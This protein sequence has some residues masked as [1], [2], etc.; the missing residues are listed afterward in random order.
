M[1]TRRSG[2]V[3]PIRRMARRTDIVPARSSS[4]ATAAHRRRIRRLT[5]PN[6]TR[7]RVRIPTW[8]LARGRCRCTRRP[9][10]APTARQQTFCA[11]STRLRAR[12]C[13]DETNDD[14][15]DESPKF[16]MVNP[17]YGV[18]HAMRESS[19]W[20]LKE[21]GRMAVRVTRVAEAD[22]TSSSV[23]LE[24]SGYHWPTAEKGSGVR[25]HTVSSVMAASASQVLE[26]PTG[27]ATITRA[28]WWAG[29]AWTAA[30][31]DD[32]VARP[33]SIRITARRWRSIGDRP[34]RYSCS[35]RCSSASSSRAT[36][37][38]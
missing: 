11:H 38:I 17:R 1:T 21:S 26:A 28:G 20:R 18:H 6:R 10:S 12:G 8:R 14:D 29:T 32:P 19:G 2:P 15:N 22:A 24:K 9:N 3:A 23:A 5:S 25:A 35:R 30:R 31:I 27:T 7:T 4:H 36:V 37:S 34:W 16:S 13:G 33:S